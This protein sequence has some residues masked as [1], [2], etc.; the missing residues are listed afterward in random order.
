MHKFF[1]IAVILVTAFTILI[2]TTFSSYAVAVSEG[3]D[4]EGYVFKIDE[5]GNIYYDY[6]IPLH[7]VYSYSMNTTAVLLTDNTF[8]YELEYIVNKAVPQAGGEDWNAILDNILKGGAAAGSGAAGG[9]TGIA[10]VIASASTGQIVLA[11]VLIGTGIVC[12]TQPEL[13]ETVINDIYTYCDYQTKMALDEIYFQ[14]TWTITDDIVADINNAIKSVVSISDGIV[15]DSSLMIGTDSLTGF[16]EVFYDAPPV[17]QVNPL[18]SIEI[19]FCN[20][21]PEAWSTIDKYSTVIYHCQREGSFNIDGEQH[22]ASSS[23][24]VGTRT[25]LEMY[26]T[27]TGVNVKYYPMDSDADSIAYAD[28]NEYFIGEPI[29]VNDGE[30]V[31]IEVVFGRKIKNSTWYEFWGNTYSNI[32]TGSTS[33]KYPLVMDGTGTVLDGQ[34]ITKISY[35]SDTG[36]YIYKYKPAASGNAD[37][38]YKTVEFPFEPFHWL[39]SSTHILSDDEPGAIDTEES[40]ETTDEY[41]KIIEKYYYYIPQLPDEEIKLDKLDN[42]TEVDS[43]PETGSTTTVET[44][45]LPDVNSDSSAGGDS[46]IPNGPSDPNNPNG[47]DFTDFI[48]NFFNFSGLFD[49]LPVNFSNSLDTMVATI[50]GFVIALVV[51]KIITA[52]P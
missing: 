44:N 6:S 38:I 9:T 48:T 46:I 45:K 50:S 26:N 13:V 33:F 52:I 30:K 37:S 42:E 41:G 24:N 31:G 11:A 40:E 20:L 14:D 15:W 29:F 47:D 23:S 32:L 2:T 12:A 27:A 19:E 1:K 7:N 22:E 3:T 36:N 34:L 10:G 49:W 21:V 16:T 43:D 28:S 8:L 39:F 35:N 4:I 51:I 5:D 18:E 17:V 25:R